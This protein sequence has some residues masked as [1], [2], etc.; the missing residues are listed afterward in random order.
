MVRGHA[1]A[2]LAKPQKNP[3]NQCGCGQAQTCLQAGQLPFVG[4]IRVRCRTAFFYAILGVRA[5]SPF[6]SHNGSPSRCRNDRL[7]PC[8]MQARPHMRAP[9][10]FRF[11]GGGNKL[12]RTGRSGRR[13][14]E[15]SG[16]W[17]FRNLKISF[18]IKI[19]ALRSAK[20]MTTL[21]L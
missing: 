1:A 16:V 7:M 9:G 5:R 12:V 8:V 17:Q 20:N 21:P 3:Q 6:L 10:D 18:L 14:N 15:A 2:S 11:W 13:R 4:T 19:C